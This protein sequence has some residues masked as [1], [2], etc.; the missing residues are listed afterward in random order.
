MG[1]GDDW[2]LTLQPKGRVLVRPLVKMMSSW[3]PRI[4]VRFDGRLLSPNK[5]YSQQT[6][7]TLDSRER[8]KEPPEPR[9]GNPKDARQQDDDRHTRND[10]DCQGRRDGSKRPPLALNELLEG[11]VL[12]GLS[13]P[14]V[15]GHRYACLVDDLN[16]QGG[17]HDPVIPVA[18]EELLAQP[19]AQKDGHDSQTGE[20]PCQ[21]ERRLADPRSV[22]VDRGLGEHSGHVGGLARGT[23]DDR[24][25]VKERREEER[26]NNWEETDDPREVYEKVRQHQDVGRWTLITGGVDFEV[27]GRG[28]YI[29]TII[30]IEMKAPKTKDSVG[31]GN[32]CTVRAYLGYDLTYTRDR[33][34][35]DLQYL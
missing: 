25:C 3:H 9:P 26:G 18:V 11:H 31:I 14:P 8:N 33:P 24:G 5:H 1:G 27:R 22:G 10:R 29:C 21:R 20:D 32:Y 28:E 7:N 34:F 12:E 16:E 4:P 23:G 13:H 19:E 30:F 6:H 2:R 15:A 17:E 35:R